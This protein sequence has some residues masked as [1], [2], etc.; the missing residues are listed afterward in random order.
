MDICLCEDDG[1][2]YEGLLSPPFPFESPELPG[3]PAD[4]FIN[5]L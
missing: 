1:G 2:F 5:I 4:G 3:P